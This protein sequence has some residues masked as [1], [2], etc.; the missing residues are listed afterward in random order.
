[1]HPPHVPILPSFPTVR[2]GEE[3]TSLFTFL[4]PAVVAAK[5]DL[6]KASSSSFDGVGDI[7]KNPFLPGLLVLLNNLDWSRS[8]DVPMVVSA[9]IPGQRDAPV[10]HRISVHSRVFSC[11]VQV[12]LVDVI[13]HLKI[14]FVSILSLIAPEFKRSVE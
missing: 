11:G 2:Q 6:T 5:S 7:G 4:S 14:D 1:L 10:V 13:H 3:D 8:A 12:K 9:Q